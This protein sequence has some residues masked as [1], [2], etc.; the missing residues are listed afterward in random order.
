MPLG[1]RRALIVG[2]RLV[3][4]DGIAEHIVPVD[5][6][7]RLRHFVVDVA[8]TGNPLCDVGRMGG[9]L[10]GDNAFL[11]VI[12]I[13]QA[14]VLCRR[15]IAEKSAPLAAAIAPPIADVIWS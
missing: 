2:A 1:R 6:V 10:A 9:N 11:Y 7:A 13:R 14:Q 12:N 4:V 3:G 5:L 8:R 15:Y